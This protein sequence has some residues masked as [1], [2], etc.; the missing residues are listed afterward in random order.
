MVRPID[1]SKMGASNCVH[2]GILGDSIKIA[3][4]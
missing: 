1:P 4:L 2:L 3:E